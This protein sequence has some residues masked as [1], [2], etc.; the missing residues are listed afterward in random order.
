[1]AATVK[2]ARHANRAGACCVAARGATFRI[3]F[4]PRTGAGATRAAG[5]AAAAF[6]LPG[7]YNPLL[8]VLFPFGGGAGGEAPRRDFFF[9]DIP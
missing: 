3:A 7:H 5:A 6:V 4:G 9:E 8:F 1:M 2:M